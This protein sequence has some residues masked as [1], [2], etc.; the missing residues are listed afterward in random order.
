MKKKIVVDEKDDEGFGVG[1]SPLH[2]MVL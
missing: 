2:T 1:G